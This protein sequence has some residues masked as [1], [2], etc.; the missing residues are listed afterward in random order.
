MNGNAGHGEPD[1]LYIAFTDKD[2]VP[3]AEGARWDAATAEDF[4]TS[5]KG[6][7]DKLIQRIGGGG[8]STEAKPTTLKKVTSPSKTP[9]PEIVVEETVVQK[10]TGTTTCSWPGHCAGKC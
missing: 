1:V 8:T 10:S 2:A 4:Q 9:Q 6:L 7:G 5:I 3:G